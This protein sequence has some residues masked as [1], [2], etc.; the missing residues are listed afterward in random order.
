MIER[1]LGAAVRPMGRTSPAA[2]TRAEDYGIG[3][4]AVAGAQREESTMTD[5]SSEATPAIVAI[6]GLAR[7]HTVANDRGETL[8]VVPA[9]DA[10]AGVAVA[11]PECARALP[12]AHF[13]YAG[14]PIPICRRCHQEGVVR[15]LGEELGLL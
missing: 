14:Q 9:R 8:T 5:A 12:P 4:R 6:P 10:A 15:A 13:R 11:C 3:Y 2:P 1:A 7:A